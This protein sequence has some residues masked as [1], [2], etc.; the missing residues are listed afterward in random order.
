MTSI[1]CFQ[2]IQRYSACMWEDACP[3]IRVCVA[4][5]RS[6]A[7]ELRTVTAAAVSRQQEGG[8]KETMGTAGDN[9]FGGAEQFLLCLL[10]S[11]LTYKM[12]CNVP[13]SPLSLPVVRTKRQ[14]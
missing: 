4:C 1:T 8:D 7:S 10:L 6:R 2:P 11:S 12:V 9:G 13:G 3:H 14:R 5:G